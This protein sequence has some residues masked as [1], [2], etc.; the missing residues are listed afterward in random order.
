MY[1]PIRDFI[2]QTGFHPLKLCHIYVYGKFPKVYARVL[3]WLMDHGSRGFRER[4]I[5]NYHGKVVRLNDARKIVSVGKTIELRNLEK[6]IPYQHA[7]DVIL[8][9]NG[10][11]AVYECMC[12]SVRPNPC[13][14]TDVCLVIGEPFAGGT[15]AVQPRKTRRIT[16]EEA[17]AI[18]EAEDR[19]GH[20]H[21]AFFKDIML[22]RLYAICNCC[23]CCCGAMRA[24]TQYGLPM[25][26]PS[27]YVSRVSDECNACGLCVEVC[28]FGAMTL[29][30]KRAAVDAQKCFGCG[31]CQTR[32]R[33]AAI[34]LAKA[35]EKGEPL[36]IEQL[37]SYS[38]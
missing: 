20:V 19:R 10:P 12:R 35:P 21:T 2:R 29:D 37:S 32:C 26:A 13:R 27:G 6:V 22:N 9:A 31:L 23:R 11:I 24:T 16:P 15:L 3:G 36:D 18:L 14:P 28:P 5:R 25:I 34:T 33:S 30:G 4:T 7:R 17:V 38:R 1:N 8:Q